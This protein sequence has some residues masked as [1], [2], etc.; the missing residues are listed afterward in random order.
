MS[1][2]LDV[3]QG[4]ASWSLVQA[5]SADYLPNLPAACIDAIVTDPPAGIGF[6]GLAFDSNKGGRDAWVAWLRDIMTEARRTLKPGCYALVWAL[7]RTSHWTATALEDAGF[8]VRDVITHHF[9]QGFPKGKGQLK[10]ASEHWILS[11]KPAPRVLPLNIDACRVGTSSTPRKD[12]RNGNLVNAHM[13]MRPWMQR[14]IDEGEPLKG[15]FEGDQGRWPANLLLTHHPACE[16]D[17]CAP[18]C[19]VAEMDRQSGNCASG[20]YPSGNH[21]RS[22]NVYGKD[23]RPRVDPVF[24]ASEGGASRFFPTFR[25]EAKASTADRDDGVD[26][27]ARAVPMYGAGIGEGHDPKAP[28]MNR[29]YHP[30][31]KPIDLMRWLCRLITPPNGVI[32]DPFTGSGSTGLAALR[33]GFRFVGI[34]RDEEYAL[35]ARRRLDGTW[36]PLFRAQEEAAR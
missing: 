7:P 30:T 25:Y 5:D 13:E 11:R 34:E 6:M 19:V 35:L 33:E 18:L 24:G 26:T 27:D 22:N 36:G 9:G 15:D 3:L 20:G 14:R 10:P 16:G 2:Y 8:D 17:V 23:R 29:N 12:P 28:A 32:L 31:V 4:R 1:D 21:I